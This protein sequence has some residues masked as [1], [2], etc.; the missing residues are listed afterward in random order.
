MIDA[1]SVSLLDADWPAIVVRTLW[2]STVL[3]ALV[4]T[5]V[6][7]FRDRVAPRWQF[8]LWGIVLIRLVM[9][10]TPESR[11]SAFNFLNPT[12]ASIASAPVASL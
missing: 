6:V 7:V 11:L 12:L 3:F 1:F 4:G 2:Q 10:V 9:V 5:C 8:V